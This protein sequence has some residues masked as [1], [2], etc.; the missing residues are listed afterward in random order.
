LVGSGV[1]RE[2]RR[3]TAR[4]R[5]VR[6]AV[7]VGV[8]AAVVASLR[9]IEVVPEF[10]WDTP[11]QVADLFLRM[12]PV[13]WNFL[14]SQALSAMVETIHIATLGTLATVV[15]AFPL[16]ILAARN[17]M[18][19]PAIRLTAKLCLVG[20][21]SVNSLVWALLFVAVFGPG[22]F[23]GTVA[24]TCRSIGFVGKLL[25]EALEEAAPGPVEALVAVGAPRTSV[26][27]KGYWPQVK[28]AFISI[29]LLR[30]DIN[31]RES[32]VLG[33]VGAGGI[34]LVLDS[35]I[36]VFQWRAVAAIL[37]LIL[38]VVLVAEVVVTFLRKRV[39]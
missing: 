24:I 23:A 29:M 21:R 35:A 36:N 19:N 18:P 5:A 38:T 27:L 11:K 10:L 9:S 17:L 16:G 37:V 28:P 4:E 1:A 32:S 12:W 20:S 34:G 14:V 15:I 7:Y 22:A 30:W 6:S 26:F 31:V 25:G 13:D 33:L 3:F 39:I 2:W 8:V